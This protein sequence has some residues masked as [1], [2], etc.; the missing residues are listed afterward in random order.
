MS[1]KTEQMDLCTNCLDIQDCCYCRNK[2]HPVHFCE[3]FTCKAPGD[4]VNEAERLKRA[5]ARYLPAANQAVFDDCGK[6]VSPHPF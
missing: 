5:E 2:K 3:E 1:E 4:L 6:P